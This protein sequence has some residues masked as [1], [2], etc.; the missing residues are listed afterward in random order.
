M[1]NFKKFFIH[2][3][4]IRTHRRYVI[5]WAFKLGIPWRGLVHDLSKYSWREFKIYKFATGLRSPHQSARAE[6]GYSPSHLYH[7]HHNKH[8]YEFWLDIDDLE[9]LDHIHYIKIPYVYIIEMVCD[10]VSTG[11]T[12]YGK[13]WKCSDP[14]KYYLSNFVDKKRMHKNSDKLL[15][16]LLEKLSNCQTEK[17]FFVWYKSVKK[18]LKK[19][20]NAIDN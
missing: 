7:K 3:R 13:A 9:S 18:S 17:E 15:A 4:T 1:S 8:H 10:M 20:Y 5:Q 11:K 19:A 16:F 12:Y 6:L 2:L 14:Y